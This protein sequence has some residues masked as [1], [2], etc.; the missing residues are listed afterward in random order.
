MLTEKDSHREAT[1]LANV[2]GP[3]TRFRVMHYQGVI[4]TDPILARAVLRSPHLDKFRFQYSFLDEFLGGVN[5]LT[6]PT[7]AHWKALRKGVA[8]AFSVTNM[9]SAFDVIRGACDNLSD[10]LVARAKAAGPGGTPEPL[11]VDNILLR[12]SMDVIGRVGFEQDMGALAAFAAGDDGEKEGPGRN[13]AVMLAATEEIVDRLDRP[14]KQL[15]FWDA[16]VKHG[17]ALMTHWRGVVR[18]LL[19]HI[20]ATHTAP[21]SFC[22]LLQK[23]RDPKTGE[24]L[25]DAQMAPEIAA[26][27]FAGIDTTGHTGTWALYLLS[28]H[29]DVEA[30]ILAELDANELLVTPTRRPTPRRVEWADLAKLVYLQA[31]IK[32]VLRMYPP[33]GIGQI[34]VCHTQDLVLA[35]GRLTVPRG[36]L[37]WVP[38]HAMQNA[39]HNWDEPAVFKP[40]RWLETAGCEYADR[41]PMPKEW[42]GGWAD[43]AAAALAAGSATSPTSP[44]AAAA[45]D[46]AGSLDRPKRYFPF[47]DGPRNC[48]GQSLA[49]TTLPTTLAHLLARFHFRLA[50]SM[51]GAA[52][53]AKREQYTL[54][55]GIREGMF[56]HA[57][58]RPGLLT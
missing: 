48:V 37:V 30:K 31:F 20:K 33:V 9:K 36:A 13:V 39:A 46:A 40:E 27:F 41:L 43:D 45:A 52:G 11:N 17:H 3:V 35:G 2:Y 5:L 26:L 56:M 23:V 8:P 21:G 7:N 47:A 1:R 10:I 51:G 25:T 57:E 28:Q 42:Y 38:H 44:T 32:E 50:D 49:M 12:E 24:P 16:G 29:P 4:V 22:T 53:V 58:P 18:K 55:V 54:V 14:H 6:G 34:R 15:A 19:A